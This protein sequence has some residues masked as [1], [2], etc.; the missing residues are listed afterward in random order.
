MDMDMNR[1]ASITLLKD[2]TAKKH[3]TVLKERMALWL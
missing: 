3:Y 1:V 2:A